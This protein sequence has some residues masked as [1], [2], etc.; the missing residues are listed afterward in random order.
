[1][2]LVVPDAN[3]LVSAILALHPNA[4]SRRVLDAWVEHRFD[5]LLSEN[6]IGEARRTLEKR[7]FRERVSESQINSELD[8]LRRL[9]VLTSISVEVHGVATHP[10][11]DLVIATAVSGGADYIVTGDAKL[12]D[13]KVYEGVQIC[14]PR[15]FL[16]VLEGLP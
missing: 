3:V 9:A 11:D 6:L 13:L 12:I 15:D 10:E 4:P 7:Y 5:I 1:V 8:R 16:W 14:S 2:T